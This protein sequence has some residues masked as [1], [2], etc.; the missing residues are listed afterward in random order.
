MPSWTF[1]ELLFYVDPLLLIRVFLISWTK[2]GR[3]Y[4][5]RQLC[6]EQTLFVA[7]SLQLHSDCRLPPFFRNCFVISEYTFAQNSLK[8]NNPSHSRHKQQP[9]KALFRRALSAIAISSS[10]QVRDPAVG[11]VYMTQAGPTIPGAIARSPSRIRQTQ[12]PQ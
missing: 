12:L 5:K 11:A 9:Q 1:I 7:R 6:V 2:T 3:T 4:V 10:P 8:L